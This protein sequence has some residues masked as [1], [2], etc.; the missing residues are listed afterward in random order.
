MRARGGITPCTTGRMLAHPAGPLTVAHPDVLRTA[1]EAAVMAPSAHNAQP[2]R[3]RIVGDVLEVLADQARQ[4]RVIDAERRQQIHGCGCALYNARIAVRAAGHEG[5]VTTMLADD[6]HPELL[7]TLHL[8]APHVATDAELDLLRAIPL[9]RT[10]R[11]AFLPRPVSADITNALIA[12]A[13]AE[14]AQVVRLL[15]AQK[16]VLAH[17]I[18][19]ADQLQYGDPAFRAELSHW[20]IPRGSARRDGIPFSEKE[21]GSNLPFTLM[22]K[23][24]STS[25]GADFGKLEEDLVRGAPVVLV[26]GTRTDDPSEW[27]ACGQALQAILLRATSLGMA[28]AFLNQVVE[29]PAH[30]AQIAELCPEVGLP[31][32]V[33]RLGYPSEPVHHPAPRRAVDDVLEIAPA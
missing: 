21:F 28:A 7:A 12:A 22:R 32:M 10:N 17:L 3:F 9:R 29:L 16:Q 6:A 8:G 23:L 1:V 11:H 33:L 20:L 31:Q 25:L 27:L 15:P 18:D 30:R 24:R 14:G 13:A 5:E 26:M 4:L 19:E 2:W